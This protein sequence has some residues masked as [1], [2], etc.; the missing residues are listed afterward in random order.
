[1]HRHMRTLR[2]FLAIYGWRPIGVLF[3]ILLAFAVVLDTLSADYQELAEQ[4]DDLDRK[5]QTMRAKADSQPKLE[6]LLRQRQQQ[7]GALG[8]KYFAAE[9]ADMAAPPLRAQVETIV[10]ASQGHLEGGAAVPPQTGKAGV[11][12]IQTQVDFGAF[13][14]H[15]VHFLEAIDKS[16]RALRVTELTAVV[17][18]PEQPAELKVSAVVQGVAIVPEGKKADRGRVAE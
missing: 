6:A 13:T 17:T 7:F 5:V 8:S 2:R 16:D 9:S 12:Y 10:A 14:Q 1:L 11:T 15:L 18:N 3:A 4:R